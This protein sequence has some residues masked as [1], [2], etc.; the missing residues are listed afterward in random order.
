MSLTSLEFLA[1]VL[2]AA[3][4]YYAVPL[5][6][7]WVAILAMNGF[8]L[9]KCDS[10]TELI[11]WAVTALVAFFGALFSEKYSG[12]K[13]SKL[14][15]A[16]A[17]III[18]V[19]M[20]LLKDV[21]GILSLP[22]SASPIGISYYSLTWI[23]YVLEVYWGIVKAERN[24]LKFLAFAGFFPALTS[25]PIVK[26]SEVGESITTGQRFD[27]KNL[28][29]GAQ[30]IAWG[31]MKKLIIADRLGVFVDR[32]YAFPYSYQ[33]LYLWIAT[34]MFVMQLY[35]DFS[36]CI[37]IALGTAEIFGIT[38]PE[39]FN[40]PFLSETLEEFWRRWH[41]TLGGWLRDYILYPL[42][43]LPLFVKLGKFSKEH[44]GK[45]LGKKIPTWIGLMISWFLVG[46]WHGGHWNYIFGVG[47]YCGFVI[48][49][50][51]ILSPL[52][53][54]LI[55]LL[56]I[57]TE[58]FSW[59]AFRVVR[60]WLLFMIGLSFFRAQGLMFGFRNI[61]LSVST[62]NPWILF[63]GSLYGLGLTSTDY[64][65]LVFFIG[66]VIIASLLKY[67][68]KKSVREF[69]SGQNIVF[70]WILYILL[71]Y[72]IIVYGCYGVGFDSASF[73]Y[74]GF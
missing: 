61:K 7:R 60:T 17:V 4:L 2:V 62:F 1:T 48:I 15:S 45:K 40:L 70:R 71:V 72:A 8:F 74:Q 22:V 19:S 24:P 56:K 32:V 53:K 27:Y 38:L 6:A 63:D 44:F 39:N 13:K 18:G 50:G 20:V 23:S 21:G 67:F 41:I 25:G 3:I 68:T 43:R 9:W 42:L 30:R 34:A 58:A 73:I 47:I 11:I 28:T 66:I 51:D 33:G 46:F 57:N 10:V 36:G 31:F 16:L 69:V 64:H 29:F 52:F 37:D 5:K 26:Y 59:K 14:F 65:I 55:A 54:K 12:T 49:M 35:F